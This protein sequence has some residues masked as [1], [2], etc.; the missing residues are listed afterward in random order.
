MKNK[1]NGYAMVIMIVI[2]LLGIGGF[3]NTKA[4]V[5]TIYEGALKGNDYRQYSKKEKA[6]YAVGLIDGLLLAPFLG[7]PEDKVSKLY[8]CISRLLKNSLLYDL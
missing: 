6:A 3:S 7:A 1:L 4:Q 2:I 5:V 8:D